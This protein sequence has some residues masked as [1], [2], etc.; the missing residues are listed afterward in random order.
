[1]GARA[2]ETV[3]LTKAIAELTEEKEK[4]EKLDPVKHK[5]EIAKLEKQIAAKEEELSKHNGEWHVKDWIHRGL[6]V[7]VIVA[8][9]WAAVWMFGGKKSTAITSAIMGFI[10]TC[11]NW[12]TSAIG[13]LTNS[14]KPLGS[15]AIGDDM[16]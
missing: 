15:A 2:K 10:G 14:A 5:K 16:V 9:I 3:K 4:L 11:W 13:G 12:I 7:G 1:M 8:L 6:F